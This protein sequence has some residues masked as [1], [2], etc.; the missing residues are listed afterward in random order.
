METSPDLNPDPGGRPSPVVVRVYQLRSP[1]A[2][3]NADFFALYD[4]E[5]ATLGQNLITPA[6]EFQLQPDESREYKTELDLATK[7]LG[8]IAAFR[9]LEN[10]RWRAFVKLPDKKKVRLKIK[11]ESL[12]VSVST[13]KR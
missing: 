9:D 10:A 3:Q 8:V 13:G 1:G 7:Y 12:A 6:E 5:I 4:N 11:L 2:F